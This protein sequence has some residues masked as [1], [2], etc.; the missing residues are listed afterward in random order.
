[1]WDTNPI[2]H[3][4]KWLSSCPNS[5]SLKNSTPPLHW[6]RHLYHK[7]NFQNVHDSVSGRSMLLVCMFILLPI[8]HFLNYRGFIICCNIGCS[9]L[10]T[11]MTL[12]IFRVF[13][14]SLVYS[15]ACFPHELYNQLVLLQK[16]KLLVFF[17]GIMSRSISLC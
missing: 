16:G 14:D 5:S 17:T 11:H 6:I 1:M 10:S 7:F 8:S 9:Q 13:L 3:F 15:F 2:S 4:S 12:K